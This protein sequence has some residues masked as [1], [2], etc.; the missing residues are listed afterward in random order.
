MV[1]GWVRAW[2]R[3]QLCQLSEVLGGG[4]QEE[5][6]PSAR[7]TSQPKPVEAQDALHRKTIADF[8]RS[9]DRHGVEYREPNLERGG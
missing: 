9:L 6:V 8:T 4:S 1:S 2:H 7:W 3:Y 5:L